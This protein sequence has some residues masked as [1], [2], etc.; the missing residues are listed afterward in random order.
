MQRPASTPCRHSR[1]I[2]RPLTI[3]SFCG[4]K[5]SAL[6]KPSM[7]NVCHIFECYTKSTGA[8]TSNWTKHLADRVRLANMID[9]C[10]STG[11]SSRPTFCLRHEVMTQISENCY[12]PQNPYLKY[13]VS[14][15][16]KLAGLAMFKN[17]QCSICCV[18]VVHLKMEFPKNLSH[19]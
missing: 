9:Q 10:F 16:R 12:S 13:S 4:D 15:L 2:F 8:N 18:F 5:T 6:E 11:L 17:A 1:Q 14:Y 3:F 7:S 19:F